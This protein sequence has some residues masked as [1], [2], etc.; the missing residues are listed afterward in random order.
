MAWFRKKEPKLTE[1]EWDEKSNPAQGLIAL[2]EGSASSRENTFNYRKQYE[3]LEIV[4]RAV[5]MVVDDSASIPFK[6]GEQLKLVSPMAKGVRKTTLERLLNIEPN[7]YQDISTFKRNIIIDLLIDGN[8]FLYWDG[9]CLYH[10]P[11]EKVV[12]EPDKVNYIKKF[13]YDGK[14]EY[15]PN[16]IIHIKE[17]SFYSIYR[18]TPRLKPAS[19]TMQLL[20]SMRSF[21]DT[22]FKNNAVPGLVIKTPN[23][24]SEKIKNR[25]L[26]SWSLRYNP[27]A[28]GRRPLILDGGMEIDSIS[29]V[30]FKELDF[31]ASIQDNEHTILKA[32]GVPPILFDGGNNANIRPNHRLFYLE[33]ILPIVHKFN[34]AFSKFFGYEVCEDITGVPAL[35]PEL[36]D[37]ASYLSTLVNGGILTANEARVS[38]GK[39]VIEGHDDVRIPANIAGSAANPSEGGKPKEPEKD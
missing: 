37:Q 22:F 21:Q 29:N 16:E 6:V 1:A 10:L 12:I 27:T 19:R 17:N 4:N 5:N 32:I 33:T 24:L 23:T 15:F 14:V 28:G 13:V 25:L 38:I 31:Q 20:T 26:A 35:Q 39:D 3:S 8:I 9:I 7:P 2:T 30:N 18:G 34:S 36:N 11:A